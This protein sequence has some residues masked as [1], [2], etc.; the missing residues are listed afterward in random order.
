[1]LCSKTQR[2]AQLFPDA[3][4][5]CRCLFQKPRQRRRA[6]TNERFQLYDFGLWTG[7]HIWLDNSPWTCAEYFSFLEL[8]VVVL[9]QSV[10]L[11]CCSCDCGD[12]L[13][14]A[15]G[16]ET[17]AA[18][19]HIIFSCFPGTHGAQIEHTVQWVNTPIEHTWY[20][21]C[22]TR[23]HRLSTYD[24]PQM[25]KHTR[26]IDVGI[27]RANT[28]CRDGIGHAL[29]WDNAKK[30]GRGVMWGVE[31]G[32]NAVDNLPSFA[33]EGHSRHCPCTAMICVRWYQAFTNV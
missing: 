15:G 13:S 28:R 3:S 26:R 11:S 14:W 21:R 10:E 22:S 6:E 12:Y 7:Q 19:I 17:G 30:R 23:T 29:L 16:G 9:K 20:T 27:R 8:F 33:L 5:P 2:C 32:L 18:P 25:Q 4:S 31:M 1:M 24:A